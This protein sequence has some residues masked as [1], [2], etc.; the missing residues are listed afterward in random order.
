MGSI[1]SNVYDKKYKQT[2][3]YWG[4]KPSDICFE[5]VKLMS[6]SRPVKLLDIGCGE[7]RNSLFFARNGY[8]VSAFD[9]SQA[10]VYK[11][12]ELGAKSGLAIDAF[13][14]DINEYR[15]SS[16]FDIVFGTGVLQY[17][18]ETLRSEII[19]NYKEFTRIGGLNVFSVLI[20]KPFIPKAPDSEPIA[21]EWKSGEIFMHYHDW[22][23]LHCTEDIFDCLSGGEPHQHAVNRIIA[24]KPHT[25]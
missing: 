25:G 12:I 2:T 17:I 24:Q 23:I 14:A 19:G 5:V 16:E 6:P 7:G 11:T 9:L 21:H 3:C 10:G 8:L 4:T 20:P 18:P 15:L 22:K 13:Y 1:V